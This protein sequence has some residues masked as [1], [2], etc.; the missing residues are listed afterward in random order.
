ML[1][2]KLKSQFSDSS[3][4]TL[5]R[6]QL[7]SN[8]NDGV[9]FLFDLAYPFC[10]VGGNPINGSVINDIAEKSSGSVA[11][12]AGQTLANVGNGFDFSTLPLT[13]NATKIN[14][15]QSG[16]DVWATIQAAQEFIVCFYIKM[17]TLAN[18]S[19]DANIFSI[20]SSSTSDVGYVDSPDPVTI[21]QAAGPAMSFRRQTA[22]GTIDGMSVSPALHHG[23][24]TQ[25]AFFRTAS[26]VTARLRSDGG[27]TETSI[28]SGSDNTATFSSISAKFGLST[29]F[30]SPTSVAGHVSGRPVLYRGFI[31]NLALSGRD[32]ATVLEDDYIRTTSRNTFS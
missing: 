1:V 16:T 31:E 14:M 13:T 22:I 15:V 3:L 10:Y 19:V 11:I 24:I 32:P 9:R 25:V 8:D 4:P 30:N 26:G 28:A 29:P 27:T 17:P 6:D 23:N 2:L 18:F 20:F 5:E 12:A 7:L 21:A